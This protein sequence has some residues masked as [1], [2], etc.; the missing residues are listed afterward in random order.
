MKTSFGLKPR[1]EFEVIGWRNKGAVQLTHGPQDQGGDQNLSEIEPP[2]E[3][4]IP[5]FDEELNPQE[6]TAVSR[7]HLKRAP[8]KHYK[9]H[10]AHKGNGYKCTISH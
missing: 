9:L 2:F 8:V 5:S 4:E 6:Q 1:P 3:V 10:G 7:W